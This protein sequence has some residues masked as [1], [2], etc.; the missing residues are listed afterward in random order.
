MPSPHYLPDPQPWAVQQLAQAH[1]GAL[2][3]FGEYGIFYLLWQPGDYD[4]GLVGFCSTCVLPFGEDAIAHRSPGFANCPNCLG[5]TFE[6]GFRARIVRPYT[7]V[8]EEEQD[9]QDAKGT[10]QTANGNIES[11][12]DFKMRVGDFLV[13]ADNSRWSI[14]SVQDDYLATGFEYKTVQRNAFGFA[15]GNISLEEPTSPIYLAEPVTV[16]ALVDLLDLSHPHHPKDFEA[17]EII[18]ADLI[19]RAPLPSTITPIPEDLTWGQAVSLTWGDVSTTTW[20]AIG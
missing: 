15:Y 14:S 20:G 4:A 11:T 16:Q 13:R 19:D 6:G 1:D 9:K 18:R 5:T 2:Y 3:R 8:F 17:F 10:Y 7:I 12:S